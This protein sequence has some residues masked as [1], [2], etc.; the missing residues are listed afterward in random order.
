MSSSTSTQSVTLAIVEDDPILRESW[1]AI[2][3]KMTGY[4]CVAKFGSAERALKEIPG[5][6][7]DMVLM[8]INLPGMTGIECTRRLKSLLPQIEIIMLTMFGDDDHLF[9]SLRAGASGYLLKRTTPAALREALDEARAGGSPMSPQ[10]ARQVVQSFRLPTASPNADDL[11]KLSEREMEIVR[12][13]SVGQAYK[14]IADQLQISVDTVRTH[15]RRIYQ[16]LQVH[17][18]TEAVV[19]YLDAKQGSGGRK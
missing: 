13:L 5:H 8:D 3:N 4:H 16:K 1:A 9:E 11:E 15:I 10:I 12:L 19:K 14:M 7:P 2:V 17:S 18:R 6:A